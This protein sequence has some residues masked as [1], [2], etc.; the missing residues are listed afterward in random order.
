MARQLADHGSVRRKAQDMGQL[1][2]R[3]YLATTSGHGDANGDARRRI[4]A[5][6]SR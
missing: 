5:D 6:K 3:L 1:G 2:K 4:S